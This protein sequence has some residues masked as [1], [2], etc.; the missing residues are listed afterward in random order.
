VTLSLVVTTRSTNSA[1]TRMSSGPRVAKSSGIAAAISSM[2]EGQA[3]LPGFT[4]TEEEVS[5]RRGSELKVWPG[6]DASA[7]PVCS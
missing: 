4:A 7:V 6:R 3:L 1:S 5:G 2:N